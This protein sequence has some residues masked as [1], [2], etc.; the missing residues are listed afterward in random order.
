[1][2]N[3]VQK[4]S[5]NLSFGALMMFLYLLAGCSGN[6]PD[7]ITA[8]DFT[9]N[10]TPA[11]PNTITPTPDKPIPEPDLK[12]IIYKPFARKHDDKFSLG[13]FDSP[14]LVWISAVYADFVVSNSNVFLNGTPRRVA[15]TNY[16][17]STYLGI[18][19][20]GFIEYANLANDTSEL[21]IRIELIR[22]DQSVI[23]VETLA[24]LEVTSASTIHTW[25]DL[26]G[27][28]HNLNGEYELLDDI[29][30]PSADRE[31]LAPWGFEPVGSS[32][33]HFTG[34]FAG[35]G[36]RIANL[37]IDRDEAMVENDLT[38]A[39]EAPTGPTGAPEGNVDSSLA[40]P[41]GPPAG[42]TDSTTGD[43]DEEFLEGLE[44]LGF[45]ILDDDVPPL[46]RCLDVDNFGDDLAGDSEDYKNYTGIWGAV[47]DA[48]SVIKDFIVDHV[49][50][51]GGNNVGAVVGWLQHGMVSNVGMVSTLNMRVAGNNKLGG[52]VGRNDG[53]VIG[54]TTGEVA[55]KNQTG[56]LVGVNDLTGTVIGYTTGKISG[57]NRVGG[58]VGENRAGCGLDSVV[59]GT[60]VGYV[61]GKVVGG[62]DVGGLVGHNEL[63]GKV[64]GYNS[65]IVDG[66]ANTGGF[67]G[68]LGNGSPHLNGYWDQKKSR[69]NVYG[70][71]IKDPENPE[72]PVAR[73]DDDH[74][75][76][77][78]SGISTIAHVVYDSGT[79][80]YM[81]TRG[82]KDTIDD[83]PVFNNN[84]S[85]FMEDNVPAFVDYF[86]FPKADATWPTLKA[87]TSF[88]QP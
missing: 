46:D 27:M 32:N 20:F 28:K 23:A 30:F 72:L 33:D 64:I 85:V 51:R 9:P 83:V 34:S 68:Y 10:E 73:D 21:T 54:Y 43:T 74:R 84:P 86:T 67:L 50:I 16:Q 31:G 66:D 40:G 45:L 49:G 59:S 65:G 41:T 24:G 71:A 79:D 69:Q 70:H 80:T 61:T 81:D 2:N 62:N 14:Y 44:G 52:L 53:A 63:N 8:G 4:M 56:G 35:N 48:G 12:K 15:K 76:V 3:A 88:P 75:G 77:G 47:G 5:Q 13:D 11:T 57:N 22:A 29:A 17:G 19:G 58:L 78:I 37:F 39:P 55:G 36:H 18:A 87:E 38:E 42:G 82:T 7:T 6:T 1:M 26:Q 25:Q 60:V